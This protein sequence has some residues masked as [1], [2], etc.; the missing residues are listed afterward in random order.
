MSTAMLA[1]S[2]GELMNI[3]TLL[4]ASA[5]LLVVA[6]GLRAL[7]HARSA[8]FLQ[9]YNT[10]EAKL[11]GDQ[12]TGGRTVL[13]LVHEY[14]G[15]I[16]PPREETDSE[17]YKRW[18]RVFREKMQDYKDQDWHKEIMK[19]M[20]EA[21]GN[22][23]PQDQ[24]ACGD[25]Q[26][27]KVL[28]KHARNAY[29]AFDLAAILAIH[30]DIP[31]LLEVLAMAWTSTIIACWEQGECFLRKRERRPEQYQCFS[32]LYVLANAFREG[33]PPEYPHFKPTALR[34]GVSMRW[35]ARQAKEERDDILQKV[36]PQSTIL[37]PSNRRAPEPLALLII[38]CLGMIQDC[39]HWLDER[40]EKPCIRSLIAQNLRQSRSTSRAPKETNS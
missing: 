5:T 2:L 39:L 3:G 1:A 20:A 22:G 9:A 21:G 7:H 4:V 37:R 14:L 40:M 6:W 19:D 35:L 12:I 25:E 30:S 18:G 17:R 33:T 13:R 32:V 28:E 24:N 31:G 36:K 16:R 8:N 11:Q 10:I 38:K 23:Q 34:S 26:T 27:G 29:G 15:S